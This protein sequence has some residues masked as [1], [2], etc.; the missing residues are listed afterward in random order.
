MKYGFYLIEKVC[1]LIRNGNL[2]INEN[3]LE[4]LYTTNNF[5]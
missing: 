3:L 1:Y 2:R 5:Y 4:I